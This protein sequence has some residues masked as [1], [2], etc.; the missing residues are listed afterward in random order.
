MAQSEFSTTRGHRG[1]LALVIILGILIILGVIGLIVSAILRF[2]RA[3]APA[4]PFT[5]TLP[6]AGEHLDSIQSDGN[7][8]LLHLSGPKGDEIVI[9]DTAGHLIGR[10]QL[11]NR[12]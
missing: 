10:I 5:V 7:R 3:A 6:A 12:P 4:Q 9:M 1:L 8:L 11:Q 2:S